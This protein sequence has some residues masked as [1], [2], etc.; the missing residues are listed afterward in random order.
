VSEI[1]Y[2]K[3]NEYESKSKIINVTQDLDGHLSLDNI[4]FIPVWTAVIS[5]PIVSTNICPHHISGAVDDVCR[6]AALD[7]LIKKLSRKSVSK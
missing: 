7:F 6:S 2:L 3:K 1:N 4:V 5:I